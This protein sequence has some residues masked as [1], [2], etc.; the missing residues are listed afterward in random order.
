M[1]ILV[2][3]ST[4]S[5]FQGFNH[6]FHTVLGHWQIK[7]SVPQ[8]PCLE[9]GDADTLQRHHDEWVKH[10]PDISY[11]WLLLKDTVYFNLVRVDGW[12]HFRH[13]RGADHG[14]ARCHNQEGRNEVIENC[15]GGG[16]CPWLPL[17]LYCNINGVEQALRIIDNHPFMLE[18]HAALLSSTSVVDSNLTTHLHGGKQPTKH[19]YSLQ[20]FKII[21]LCHVCS[22]KV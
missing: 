12:E 4:E 3:E 9:N 18:G 7:L 17:I 11:L 22:F 10:G 14:L 1:C 2:C 20:P 19:F 8:F 21:V 15:G 13:R 5:G 16:V 6:G